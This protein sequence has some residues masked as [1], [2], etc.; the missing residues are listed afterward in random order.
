MYYSIPKKYQWAMLLAASYLFYFA[1][2]AFYPL[3]IFFTSLTIFFTAKSISD[4]HE[5]VQQTALDTKTK[6]AMLKKVKKK[7]KVWLILCMLLNLGI[8]AVLKY[9]NF[10]IE[11]INSLLAL[12]GSENELQYIDF[13]VPL[14][15]SFYTFQAVGYLLDVYWKKCKAE[16]NFFKFALFVSF[17]PQLGQGPISRF[18]DLSPTLYEAHDLKWKNIKFGLTRILWG[19]FKKLVIADRIAVAVSM[20]VQDSEYY[21]GAFVFVGMVFYAIQLYADFTG[22]IDITIGIAEVFGIKVTENFNRPFF[23]KSIAEYWRRWHITMGSWFKDYVFYPLSISKP[24]KKLTTFTKNHFGLNAAKRIAI[25]VSTLMVWVATGIWHGASWNFVMWGLM[26]GVILLISQELTPIYE[27]FHQRFPSLKSNRAFH[28]FQ[29]IRT[30]L[31]MSSLRLFDNYRDVKEAF[32]TFIHMFTQFDLSVL[33]LQEFTDMGLTVA[34]YLIIA[35]G[36]CILF[37]VSMLQRTGSVRE[38]IFKKPYLVKYALFLVLFFSVLLLG[39]YGIEYDAT[40]FIYNQ[41]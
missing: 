30:L 31:L 11:S 13:I 24:L 32:L 17:F 34:D 37:M 40:Q 5:Q 29:V 12:G 36:V 22:G 38:Y 20:I 4:A 41:F 1:A 3:L 10:A 35:A 7:T 33:S 19:Y 26:N 28:G 25:Y 9:S 2:G 27:K 18:G 6:K 23:S 15:I 14:G 39:I 21:T 8:L 16:G